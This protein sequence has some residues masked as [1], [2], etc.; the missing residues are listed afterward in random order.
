MSPPRAAPAA[1]D[2]CLD[3]PYASRQQRGGT[4]IDER[5]CDLA[6]YLI[7]LTTPGWFRPKRCRC[8]C[9][10]LHIHS[11]RERQ[12]RGTA[13]EAAQLATVRIV[14]FIC[15]RCSATWRVLPAFLARGLWRTWLVVASV[16][17]GSR[18]QHEPVIPAR[19]RQLGASPRPTARIVG[20]RAA[21]CGRPGSWSGLHSKRALRRL[22]Q[23]NF[24]PRAL[25]SARRAAAS[26][27]AG[28]ASRVAREGWEGGRVAS[29]PGS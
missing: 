13:T 9:R 25:C 19:T 10:R 16:L 5:I 27:R 12:L 3:S 20:L 22:R 1:A 2:T 11:Y 26:A 23:G 6:T 17:L 4:I 14:V 7:R 24:L 28:A 15:T 21:A 18:G 29:G 8:G